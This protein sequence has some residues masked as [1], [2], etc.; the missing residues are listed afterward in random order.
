MCSSFDGPQFFSRTKKTLMAFQL[1]SYMKKLKFDLG[2]FLLVRGSLNFAVSPEG[3]IGL[4]QR[5]SREREA[6]SSFLAIKRVSS[7]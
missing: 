5:C 7:S 2:L 1:T 3:F 6:C 4:M